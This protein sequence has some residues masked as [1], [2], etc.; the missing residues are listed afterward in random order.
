MIFQ[1]YGIA[2]VKQ[3]MDFGGIKEM[4]ENLPDFV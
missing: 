1:N 3:H 4:V 2:V